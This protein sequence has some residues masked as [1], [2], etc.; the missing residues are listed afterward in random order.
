MNEA[1]T[2]L[3]RLM[4]F[5]DWYYDY[6]DDYSQWCRGRDQRTAINAEQRRVVAEGLAT[7]EEVTALTDKYRPKS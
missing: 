1:L 6:S 5:H 4:A 7:Q 2:T 3:D